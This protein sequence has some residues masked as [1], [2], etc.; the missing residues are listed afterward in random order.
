MNRTFA[1]PGAVRLEIELTTGRVDVQTSD[2][3]ETTVELVPLNSS[4]ATLRAVEEAAIIH[5]EH[6]GLHRVRVQVGK[7]KGFYFGRG[8]QVQVTVNCPTGTALSVASAAATV[9]AEGRYGDAEIKAVSGDT[10]LSEVD[11]EA[12]VKSVSGD[13]RL[14]RV[15]ARAD[16]GSVSGDIRLDQVEGACTAKTVSG[17]VMIGDAHTSVEMTTVSGD[18]QLS[19]VQA[20]RIELRSVSGDIR[21]GVRRG[22][23]VFMDV[24]SRSGDLTSEL[25][26]SAGEGEG[27]GSGAQVEIR[28][29]SVSGDISIVR[30]AG[31]EPAVDHAA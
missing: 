12:R 9:R 27:E 28:A 3:E 20:G 24:N 14:G 19:A 18:Q 15:G 5:D 25:D 22:T 8:P 16:L 6:S 1:T 11:G 7:Q 31:R 26:T 29:S 4:D 30:A 2:T 13:M 21:I 23:G 10:M 17:D